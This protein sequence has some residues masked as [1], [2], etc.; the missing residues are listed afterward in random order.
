MM[1]GASEDV[2]EE[3]TPQGV[4]WGAFRDSGAVNLLTTNKLTQS[5]YTSK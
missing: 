5:D 4:L 1:G 2:N 3:R